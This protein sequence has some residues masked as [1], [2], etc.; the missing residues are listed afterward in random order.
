M[1]LAIAGDGAG[2]P[3]VEV[4]HA[5]LSRQPDISVDDLSVV[6]DGSEEL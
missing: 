5:H 1:K 3:L 4:L 2:K 6:P